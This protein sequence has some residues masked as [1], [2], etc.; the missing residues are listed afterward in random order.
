MEKHKAWVLAFGFRF[1]EAKLFIAVDPSKSKQEAEEITSK[2]LDEY[3][4]KVF[5]SADWGY[6]E[7]LSRED[8][9][10]LVASDV[11]TSDIELME[12][13]SLVRFEEVSDVLKTIEK[14]GY[15]I[16]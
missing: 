3:V 10:K 12:F 5:E 8:A 16:I 11:W 7:C 14:Q 6:P 4:R 2:V 15:A 1:C 9:F 13:D